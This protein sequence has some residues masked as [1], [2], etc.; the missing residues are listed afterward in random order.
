[1]RPRSP[2]GAFPLRLRDV[3]SR[4]EANERRSAISGA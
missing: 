1:M 2:E 3:I 4:S